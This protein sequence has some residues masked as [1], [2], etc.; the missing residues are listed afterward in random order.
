MVQSKSSQLVDIHLAAKLAAVGFDLP[1]NLSL[2]GTGLASK[3]VVSRARG[4][5]QSSTLETVASY[6]YFDIIFFF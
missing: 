6:F 1:R 3:F 2:P 4:I 5:G